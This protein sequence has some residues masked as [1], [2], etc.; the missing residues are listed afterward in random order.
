MDRV[1]HGFQLGHDFAIRE[2]MEPKSLANQIGVPMAIVFHSLV[3]AMLIAVQFDDVFML[4]AKEVDDIWSECDLPAKVRVRQWHAFT[5]MPPKMFL[6][7]GCIAAQFSGEGFRVQGGV[8]AMGLVPR[9][10]R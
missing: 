8:V 2:A 10:Q 5:Q 9:H 7:V 3:G 6:G 4:E 1:E